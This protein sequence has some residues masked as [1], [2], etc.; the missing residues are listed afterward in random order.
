MPAPGL[1][2]QRWLLY[3]AGG[4]RVAEADGTVSCFL[5]RKCSSALQPRFL[6]DGSVRVRMPVD[7]RANGMWHGPDPPE[8][9][10]LSYNEAKVINLA[11]IYVSVKRVFL[12][13][14]SYAAT[15]SNDAPRYHQKNVVAYPQDP[16]A[17][18]RSLGMGPKAS[19][20]IVTVQ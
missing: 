2:E 7:A 14:G 4:L 9:S 16:D 1:P 20:S 19:A 10:V 5:C 17:A 13:R 8:L 3:R 6:R 11:R 12:H 18:L 15:A